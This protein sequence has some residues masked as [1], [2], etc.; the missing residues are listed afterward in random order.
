MN[1]IKE[2][3]LLKP[4]PLV[5][6][7]LLWGSYFSWI[8]GVNVYKYG[9]AHLPVTAVFVPL[10]ASIIGVNRT[11]LR[12]LFSKGLLKRGLKRYVSFVL[13]LYSLGY[14]VLY[15]FPNRVALGL[16]GHAETFQKGW[17]PYTVDFLGF[18][19]AFAIKGAGFAAV[20][21]LYSTLRQWH[22]HL[23]ERHKQQVEIKKDVRMR[24]WIAHFMG[25]LAQSFI[26]VF[27]KTDSP[28]KLFECYGLILAYGAQMMARRRQFYIGFQDEVYYLERL[29]TIYRQ[30]AIKVEYGTPLTGVA[31]LPMLLLALYK[32]IY[33]H[34]NFENGQQALLQ[35][36]RVGDRLS[37][38]NI[39]KIA[40][41]SAWVYRKGGTGLEQVERLLRDQYAD[42]VKIAY[43]MHKDTFYLTIEIPVTYEYEQ[44]DFS[45][46]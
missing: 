45:L 35:I 18:Y 40:P 30:N 11:A 6:P 10:M 37:I 14:M 8:I 20:E 9:W 24:Q 2:Q 3:H 43:R 15:G 4:F 36:K 44:K 13:L 41:S 46:T 12:G 38:I 27:R 7:V 22:C 23:K 33:K 34:G 25:N 5:V 39:N 29:R 26:I 16:L 1:A 31:V 32:N 19:L 21:M 42:A 17:L 28:L